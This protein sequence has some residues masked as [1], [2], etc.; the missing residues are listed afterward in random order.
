MPDV[1]SIAGREHD[2][3]G[4]FVV[5]RL[6]PDVKR[7]SVGP[8]IFLDHM[9]PHAFPPGQGIDVRPHPHIGLSTLTW[10]WDGA[11]MHRDSVGSVQVIRPG[12]VNWMTAGRGIVHSERTP[13]AERAS[14]QRVEGLQT[15][16]AMPESEA[17]AT[18]S[19]QHVPAADVPTLHR[20]GVE[21]TIVA[22]Q[23]FG[24]RSPVR[25]CVDTLY[26]SARFAP[27]TFLDLDDEHEERA[28]YPLEDGLVL[29]GEPLAARQ[30]HVLPARGSVRLASTAAVRAMLLGGAPVGPCVL[31]WNFVAT[32]R[33]RIEQAK[34]DWAAQ[35]LGTV[36]GESEFI[37][38]PER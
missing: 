10:L 28:V 7:R 26:V 11:L 38:L 12:D 5:R 2:L 30:L 23:A 29:D 20:E 33:E 22:G 4:G 19:F 31:W 21:I 17:E 24:Q 36:P 15:W 25:T 16:L 3:G 9:G 6:L 35:A 37:P 8:F 14:G 27:G 13:D 1:L 18:P 32:S 34:A